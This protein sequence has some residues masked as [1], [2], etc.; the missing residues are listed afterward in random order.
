MPYRRF[1]VFLLLFSL[2]LT[3]P[4]R[5]LARW[6]IL[7]GVYYTDEFGIVGSLV[8]ITEA[9]DGRRL[10]L[11]LAYFGEDEG[12]AGIG[13]FWPRE[14]TEW[15]FSAIH[16]V[17]EN[18]AHSA[19]DASSHDALHT[20]RHYLTDLW[21]RCDFLRDQG[22]FYGFEGAYRRHGFGNGSGDP[23][24]DAVFPAEKDVFTEGEEYTASLRMGMERRDNRYDSYNG[25]YLLWQLDVGRAKTRST[26]DKLVRMQVDVRRYFPIIIGTS[27]LAMNFRAGIIHHKVPYFS[28]FTMG[29]SFS[30]RGFPMDRYTGNAF[31]LL[32]AEYRHM[33]FKNLPNPLQLFKKF[34]PD[35]ENYTVSL[36]YSIFTDVSDLWRQDLDW[37]GVRQGIGV[38]LRAVF[39]PSV[40][41]SIDI[42]TPVDSDYIA[43]YLNLEQSF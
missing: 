10:S 16:Q 12:Q 38:G 37:W 31:Y 9:D 30:L 7:P 21:I 8:F 35:L 24:Y 40:V 18:D 26:S 33:T 2:F 28:R 22:L 6:F 23:I 4:E 29:G 32:R 36:G 25:Y 42:A 34:N 3:A 43:V 5:S 14:K 1:S 20:D 15:T 27:T 39:P 17:Y 11:S 13:F 19:L 41:A